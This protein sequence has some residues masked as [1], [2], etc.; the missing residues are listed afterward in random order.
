MRLSAGNSADGN[1]NRMERNQMS[2]DLDIPDFLKRQG[3]PGQPLAARVTRRRRA[4]VIPYP[5]AGYKR[6]LEMNRRPDNISE[7]TWQACRDSIAERVA[8]M[9]KLRDMRGW[10]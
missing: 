7:A 6:L 9:A 8:R 4:P 3:S 1:A 5:P 2:D 10:K